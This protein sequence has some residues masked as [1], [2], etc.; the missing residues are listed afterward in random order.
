MNEAAPPRLSSTP[1]GVEL[2]PL[3]EITDGGARGYVLEMRAGRFFG[4]ILR[5]GTKVSGFV[6]RCP[7]AGLPLAR[8]LD[9]YLTPAG[10]HIACGWHGALFTREEGLCVGGPC[11]GQRLIPWPVAVRD[12]TLI[13]A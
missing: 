13:T 12:G 6:D 11:M 2:G 1:A 9:D 7:H 10:D 4:F 8:E 5:D 3:T